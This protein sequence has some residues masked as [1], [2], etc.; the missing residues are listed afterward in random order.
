MKERIIK[1]GSNRE[2]HITEKE[3][4]NGMKIVLVDKTN[5]PIARYEF[6]RGKL[7]NHTI[8][9]YKSNETG[10]NFVDIMPSMLYEMCSIR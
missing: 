6:N 5:I 4:A 2:L 9:K 3:R 1:R 10:I 8:L 7:M